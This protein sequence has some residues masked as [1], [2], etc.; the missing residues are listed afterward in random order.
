M[1]IIIEII[2]IIPSILWIVFALLIVFRF[3]S[4]INDILLPRL[5]KIKSSGIEFE[6]VIDQIN[7]ALELAEKMPKWNIKVSQYEKEIIQKRILKN[8]ECFYNKKIAWIDDEPENLINEISLLKNLNVKINIYKSNSSFID[9][10][11]SDLKYD[12]VLSDIYRDNNT[13][14]GLDLLDTILVK[15]KIPIIFYIGTYDPG[16]GTPKYTFGITNKPNELFHL[17]IDVFNRKE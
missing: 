12:L 6:F 2:K 10:G 5:G 14:N 15:E 13:G 16:L 7:S 8:K 11:I 4:S 17:I 9:N 3:S 1:D